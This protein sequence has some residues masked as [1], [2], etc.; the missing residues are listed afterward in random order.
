MLNGKDRPGPF[1]HAQDWRKPGPSSP[2]EGEGCTLTRPRQA[3]ADLS[4]RGRGVGHS[5][6]EGL[7]PMTFGGGGFLVC[8]WALDSGAE[9]R[10]WW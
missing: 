8:S 4:L 3:G 9:A 7:S 5:E 2:F 10:R 6:E 1:G